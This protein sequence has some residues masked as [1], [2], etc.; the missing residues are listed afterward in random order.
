MK[1]AL[2]RY[3]HALWLLYLPIYLTAFCL[4]E[5]YTSS[6]YWVSYTPLD[7]QIPFIEHF[8]IAYIAWFPAISEGI[9][10]Q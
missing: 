5:K 4:A 6:R 7:D 10:G 2:H 1:K 3:K 8:V 9:S